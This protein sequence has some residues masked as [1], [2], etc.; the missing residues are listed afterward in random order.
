MAREH[1]G[2]DVAE[3]TGDKALRKGASVEALSG[4]GSL[5]LGLCSGSGFQQSFVTPGLFDFYRAVSSQRS[6]KY[7]I[8]F[9]ISVQNYMPFF[10]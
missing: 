10:I 2:A 5:D 8:T 3:R 9:I 1:E 7:A 4:L 6:L